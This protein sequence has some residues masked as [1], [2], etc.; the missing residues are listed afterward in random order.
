MLL[1]YIS[2]MPRHA[3]QRTAS[4]TGQGP[5]N[6]VVLDDVLDAD[7]A[8]TAVHVIHDHG[9]RGPR[10]HHQSH[11]LVQLVVHLTQH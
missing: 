7:D 4:S 11:Y 3:I 2:I 6:Q 9:F 10:D 1:Y 5:P 8:D